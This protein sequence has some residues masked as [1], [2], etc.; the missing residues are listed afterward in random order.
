ML[1][2]QNGGDQFD[3]LKGGADTDTLL[4]IGSS[5]TLN[6]FDATASS[7][8]LW[9]GQALQSWLAIANSFNRLLG[10]N[11]GETFDFSGLTGVTNLRYLDAGAGNDTLIGSDA[12]AGDLRGGAGNDIIGGGALNDLLAGGAGADTFVVT[13]GAD[14][15]TDLTFKSKAGVTAGQDDMIDLTAY[16]FDDYTTDVHD[17]MTQVGKHVLIDFGGGNTLKINNTTIAILDAHANDFLL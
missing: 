11:A 2:V 6:G 4:A 5:V 13:G 12:W 14:T 10:T 7:I 1:V 3:V 9:Q 17:Q 16:N 15:I 8:E